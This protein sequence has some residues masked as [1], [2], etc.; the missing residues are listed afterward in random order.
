MSSKSAHSGPDYPLPSGI[1]MDKGSQTFDNARGGLKVTWT[2]KLNQKHI[3]DL[4]SEDEVSVT[5]PIQFGGS[6]NWKES[7]GNMQRTGFNA[8]VSWVAATFT[9][10]NE[11]NPAK[12][13]WGNLTGQQL[14]GFYVRISAVGFRNIPADQGFLG[15]L[16]DRVKDVSEFAELGAKT[17]EE[18]I[19]I[20][21]AAGKL[22]TG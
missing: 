17:A 3:V 16:K 9:R 10:M 21:Q 5:F 15:E 1:E 8:A 11:T 12:K 13:F 14:S 20:A 6:W 18:V 7:A 2:D 19:K 22:K 4:T